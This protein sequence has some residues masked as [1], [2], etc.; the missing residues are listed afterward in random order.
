M[1]KVDEQYDW[2]SPT[3]AWY[4]AI[5][6]MVT[7]ALAYIDRTIIG[8]L[9]EPIR[10]D[11]GISDTQVSLLG[12]L[13]FALFYVTMGLP[14][15]RVA[16]RANRRNLIIAGTVIWSVMTAACGL[17]SNFWQLFFTRMCVG[18]GE[19]TLSPAALS[20]I[21]DSFP[22]R[23]RPIPLGL[24]MCGIAIGSGLAFLVGGFVIA[25]AAGATQL[26]L[27]V[28]GILQPWQ[29]VFIAVGLPG[30]LLAALLL[31]IRE[32]RRRELRT[33]QGEG[34]AVVSVRDALKFIFDENRAAFLTIFVAFGGLALHSLTIPMWLPAHFRRNFGWTEADIGVPLGCLILT[35]GIAGMVGGAA[36]AARMQRRGAR[37]ALLRT[38]LIMTLLM[39]PPAIAAPLL[40]DPVAALVAIT[41]VITLSYGLF[42]LV[43]GTLYAITPN[44]LR[45]QVS[46]VFS[47]FNSAV[48]LALGGTIVALFTDYVFADPRAVGRSLALTAALVLPACALLLALGLR[49]FRSS[50]ERA[51]GWSADA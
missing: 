6:L 41:P 2:P 51:L 5:V 20:I 42:A 43:P 31:G 35:C 1:R 23:N 16:D 45:G 50:V 3:R 32:P 18:V 19:A 22:R 14:L 13:A 25:W 15:G 40:T 17:A 48:G 7:Y 37:D 38:A 29:I 27:P 46:A 21:S 49:P 36:F 9:I 47:F 28:V 34:G 4:A 33:P 30:L 24:Y 10:S 44:E 8:L 39:I 11:F 26:S 12:G